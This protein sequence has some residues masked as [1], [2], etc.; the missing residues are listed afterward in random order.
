[1][2]TNIIGGSNSV[3]QWQYFQQSRASRN[4][5]DSGNSSS[6]GS[7]QTQR[8][9]PQGSGDPA[10]VSSNGLRQLTSDLNS[11][12]AAYQASTGSASSSSSTSSS[13]QSAAAA[14]SSSSSATGGSASTGTLSSTLTSDLSAVVGDLENLFGSQSSGSSQGTGETHHHHHHHDASSQGA[15]T[16][17]TS[18]NVAS[19]STSSPT[20]SSPGTNSQATSTL[21][22]QIANA[23]KTY[24][25][26]SIPLSST[27][28]SA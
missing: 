23:F 26:D 15:S 18:S 25:S 9:P 12:L 11:F 16:T 14:S 21:L 24:S 4:T 20:T 27:S 19:P 3:S 5:S 8:L 1:M 7:V 28:T 13:G 10:G 6:S 22:S 2:S 17:P